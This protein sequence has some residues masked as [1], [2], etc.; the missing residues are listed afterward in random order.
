MSTSLDDRPTPPAAEPTRKKGGQFTL[1][2]RPGVVWLV[3]AGLVA[4]NHRF[5]PESR[6]LMVHLVMLGAMT[7]SAMVWSSHFTRTL[8]K[9]S[10][11]LDPR[12]DQGRRI[13]LLIV[14]VIC[15][16]VAVPFA[17]WPL[18][19][20]GATLASAAVIWHGL[21]L[22]R[23]LRK[24]L[25]G[26]FRI[27][28]R[29][30][31]AAAVCLPVGAAFGATLAKGLDDDLH[32]RVLLAQTMTM[33]L[34]W[35]G[36]TV[37]GTLVT[38]WPTMLR[39]RM[40][41]RAE[42]LA[43][44]A[45]P[46][47]VAGLLAIDTGALVGSRQIAV[48]GLV[49]YLAAVVW[50][51]R[52]LVRPARTAPPKHASTYFVSAALGWAAILLVLLPIQVATAAS[53]SSLADSY[54]DITSIAVV[55]FAL[56][57]LTGALSHLVPA[58]LG[59]GSRVVRAAQAEFDRFAMARLTTIDLGLVLW[60]LPLPSVARV[61]ISS[62][63]LVALAAFIPLMFKALH[64]AVAVRKQLAADP[65]L[66]G[67]EPLGHEPTAWRPVQF[68]AAT[69][70]LALAVSIGGAFDSSGSAVPQPAVT[71]TGH[72]TTVKVM[73]MDMHFS[74]SSVRVPKGDRLV[75]ELTN[76]D[77]SSP[78]DLRFPTGAKTARISPGASAI[79]DLGVIGQS[80]QGWCTVVGHK[81]MGMTFDVVV[82]G[83]SPVAG[84]SM[85]AANTPANT[86]RADKTVP[87]SFQAVDPTLPPLTASTVHKVT[88]TIREVDLEVAPGVHQK[89]WTFNG[90][91]PGPTLHGRVGDTFEIT[92][93][94][95]GSMGHS[96]DF[97]AGDVAPDQP[98]RTIAPGHSLV[99][100]FTAHRAGIWMYHC[101]TMPMSAHIAAGM[102]GAVVIEPPG[103]PTV[104]KSYL[105]VQSEAYVTGDGRTGVAEVN[106]DAVAAKK[107]SFVTFNGVANQYDF[108]QPTAKVGDRVRIW[109]LDAGPNLPTSFHVVGSQFDTV[110]AEGAYQLKD[111]KDAFG[112]GSG[113]AQALSLAPAQGGFV[114]LTPRE[115][116]HYP[117][118][119]HVMSD[120]EAGAH[121]VLQVTK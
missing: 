38:L 16:F 95:D 36:L 17:L 47:L 71:P 74:P 108:R 5:V 27:S 39:T 9:T 77:T 67:S 97:H 59:G 93:V 106:S 57:L 81:A 58:V 118:V 23:L 73:A 66:R 100:R 116:G 48:A 40:D 68:T 1:R 120:A 18:V 56:Q 69:A 37:L 34:G 22:W 31:L 61:I 111:G 49:W 29:Y 92:L 90:S 79:L 15:V 3:L 32:G 105:F 70:V 112:G 103:L 102:A 107:P 19:V 110:Y 50:W 117:F 99:Y 87:A 86:A 101:S 51:G 24:A 6:W 4:L 88:F 21:V 42:T 64:A 82:T 62:L 13:L 2:D 11:A 115:A 14:G 35:L 54:G 7:H 98:M 91:V 63:V 53:W 65:S 8:L 12:R 72:T 75:V 60:L 52:C 25:P 46:L 109:V 114:E 94:N 44:Q 30:Y 20:V 26:R 55:G 85:A 113:G 33:V 89:R 84:S 121:G 10:D 28:V 76:H 43:R 41:E 45:L 96:I 80:M 83:S 104:D 119:S 78:H